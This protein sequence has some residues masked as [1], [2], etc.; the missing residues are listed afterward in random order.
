MTDIEMYFVD[1]ARAVITRAGGD[2][3]AAGELAAWAQA[4]HARDGS[5]RERG[6]I[7]AKNGRIVAETIH[8]F[9]LES[10]ASYLAAG[11]SQR[12]GLGGPLLEV[13]T[14][15]AVAE[16]SARHGPLIHVKY[17]RV[18]LGFNGVTRTS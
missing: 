4:A 16:L 3:D 6:V 9:D 5:G 12:L 8:T 13:E 2:P 10:S 17:S 18:C 15:M 11:E 7:V 1:N 14:G